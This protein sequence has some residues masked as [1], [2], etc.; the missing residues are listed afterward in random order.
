[1]N[2]AKFFIAF[3]LMLAAVGAFSEIFYVFFSKKSAESGITADSIAILPEHLNV[4]Q[5]E[6]FTQ[7]AEKYLLV[8][9]QQFEEGVNPETVLTPTPTPTGSL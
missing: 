8:T 5:L 7:R 3:A 2:N 1:M 6:A 4:E 9:G